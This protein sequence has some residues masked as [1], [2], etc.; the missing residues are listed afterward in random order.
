[1]NREGFKS[2]VELRDGRLSTGE[3]SLSRRGSIAALL[4]FVLV[5]SVSIYAAANASTSVLWQFTEEGDPLGEP[6]LSILN[7]FR[8]R[9][10]ERRAA[11]LPRGVETRRLRGRVHVDRSGSRP[12]R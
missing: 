2:P 12:P 7:P 1:V 10:P 11:E 5:A 9:A 8:S 3:S 4:A 6:V